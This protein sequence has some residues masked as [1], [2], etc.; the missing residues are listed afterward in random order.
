MVYFLKWF[1]NSYS[2]MQNTHQFD[3]FFDSFGF[4][5]LQ[6]ALEASIL[7]FFRPSPP[8]VYYGSGGGVRS[9]GTSGPKHASSSS[10]SSS[11]ASSSPA[12]PKTHTYTLTYFGEYRGKT[13]STNCTL[14]ARGQPPPQT[15]YRVLGQGREGTLVAGVIRSLCPS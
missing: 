6:Q 3:D 13:D 4:E 10:A 2:G 8:A 12:W 1:F 7:H 5:C 11:S 15:S 9:M 14:G